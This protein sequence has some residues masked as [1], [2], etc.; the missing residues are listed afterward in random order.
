M[1]VISKSGFG[2]L[3]MW[4][5]DEPFKDLYI[6]DEKDFV[7]FKLQFYLEHFRI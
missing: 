1:G 3:G 7:P 4:N 6:L 2:M 5:R